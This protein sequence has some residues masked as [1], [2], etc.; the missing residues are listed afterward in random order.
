MKP[1]IAIDTGPLVALINASE[2]EH[3]RM[4]KLVESLPGPFLTVEPVVTEA[5]FLLRKVDRGAT[6]VLQLVRD[7]LLRISFSIQQESAALEALMTKFA[8][9]PMSLADACLVRLVEL[10]PLAKVLTFDGDFQVYRFHRNRVIPLVFEDA[11]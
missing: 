6:T 7:G 11:G 3:A 2:R 1:L 4:A 5:C 9:V 8:N 10:T